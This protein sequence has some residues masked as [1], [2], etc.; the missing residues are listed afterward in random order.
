MTGLELPMM[1]VEGGAPT[2]LTRRFMSAAPLTLSFALLVGGDARFTTVGFQ[3]PKSLMPWW[4]WGLVFCAAGIV[5]LIASIGNAIRLF[6][7]ALAAALLFLFWAYT[8]LISGLQ[9][10]NAAFTGAAFYAWAGLALA[11]TAFK[12]RNPEPPT[13]TLAAWIADGPGPSR[14]A[15]AWAMFAAS[16]LFGLG[17][18]LQLT[19]P[20][21]MIHVVGSPVTNAW[22]GILLGFGLVGLWALAQVDQK[23]QWRWEIPARYGVAGGLLTYSLV[24]LTFSGAHAT[25]AATILGGI[26]IACIVRAV[27]RTRWF[28][29]HRAGQ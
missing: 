19:Q 3:Y 17:S 1:R 4:A 22:S 15:D 21:S 2:G 18:V 20:K 13:I 11:A 24:V 14:T 29:K 9:H 27:A 5:M 28:R 6:W 7:P 23:D 26:G 10:P 12:A 25:L 8:L 16:T